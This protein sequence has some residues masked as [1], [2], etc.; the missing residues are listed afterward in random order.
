MTSA[1]QTL[2]NAAIAITACICGAAIVSTTVQA[3]AQDYASF[4]LSPGFQPARA[5]GSGVSGGSRTVVCDTRSTGGSSTPEMF[6]DLENSPDH[7]LTVSQPF[8]YLRASVEAEGDVTLLITG[9]DGT[10]CSDDVN[11]VLPEISGSWMAGTYYIWVGDF[12][13]AAGSNYRY[14]LLFSED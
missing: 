6:V 10:Y 7:I 8:S 2:R 11:G 14:Q 12:D 3:D 9:P 1:I 5:V 13:S 4:T